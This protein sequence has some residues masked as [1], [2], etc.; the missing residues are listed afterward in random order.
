V[1]VVIIFGVPKSSSLPAVLYGCGTWSMVLR[2]E[3]QYLERY[4]SENNRTES[5]QNSSEKTEPTQH[6]HDQEAAHPMVL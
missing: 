1:Q 6:A 3:T 4:L 2:E 5:E